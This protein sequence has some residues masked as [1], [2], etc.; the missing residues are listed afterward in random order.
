MAELPLK[1]SARSL[2]AWQRKIAVMIGLFVVFCVSVWSFILLHSANSQYQQIVELVLSQQ[3]NIDKTY[4]KQSLSQIDGITDI[5]DP[6]TGQTEQINASGWMDW[7]NTTSTFQ[8]ATGLKFQV[9]YVILATHQLLL[10]FTLLCLFWLI[11]LFVLWSIGRITEKKLSALER[12]ARRLQIA[13]RNEVDKHPSLFTVLDNLLDELTWSRQEQSRVDKFIRIQTFLDPE[14]GI[15]NRV[16]FN[17]RLEALL[18]IEE[19]IEQGVVIG[20]RI[21]G[22]NEI[23]EK[24]GQAQALEVLSQ[25]TNITQ[26]ALQRYNHAIFARYSQ[27][28]LAILI[29]NIS[30][31][32]I[33]QLCNHLVRSLNHVRVPEKTDVDNLYHMGVATFCSGN[34]LAQVLREVDMA[35]RSAELQGPASWFMFEEEDS[36]KTMTMGSLQWRTLLENRLSREEFLISFQAVMKISPYQIHHQELLVQL[37]DNQGKVLPNNLFMPMAHKC[38]LAVKIDQ[39]IITKLY[40]QLAQTDNP[41]LT[42]INLSTDALLDKSFRTWFT[43][44]LAQDPKFAAQIIVEISEHAV[45]NHLDDL[46]F[47]TQQLDNLST[48]VLIDQVGQYVTASNYIKQ[49][50]IRYLKLHPSIVKNIH[51]KSENQLFIRSL[52]GTCAGTGI[53][54]FAYGVETVEE[55]Q[56]IKHLGLAGIQGSYNQFNIS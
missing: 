12:K 23:D 5:I 49:L 22:L 36:V 20:I 14:T 24:H 28:D 9:Q 19:Q 40:Q 18:N 51:N 3:A 53:K 15:G 21:N 31:R 17:N 43:S 8:L 46:S 34:Q 48:H 42:S 2:F 27:N 50:P 11:A 54:I 26:Q 55:Y 1:T 33:E 29:A 38:G 37:Q 52:Q 39:Q 45:V 7:K 56:E 6:L 25:F 16:Y 41:V 35:I 4:L 47:F 30:I 13:S 32:E 10:V 44:I